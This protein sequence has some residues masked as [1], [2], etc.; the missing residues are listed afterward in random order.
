MGALATPR[1]GMGRRGLQGPFAPNSLTQHL[2]YTE[3]WTPSPPDT[4]LPSAPF[5][6]DRSF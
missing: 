1:V 5:P 2:A 6:S 4:P 3:A